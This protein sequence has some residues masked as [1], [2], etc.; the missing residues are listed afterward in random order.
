MSA[1]GCT[2]TL[3]FFQTY[4]KG[5]DLEMGM[6]VNGENTLIDSFIQVR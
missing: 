2:W 6:R 1:C 5:L 3:L 4:I